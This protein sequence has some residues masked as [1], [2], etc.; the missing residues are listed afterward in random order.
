MCAA[1]IVPT[2]LNL[3]KR[4]DDFVAPVAIDLLCLLLDEAPMQTFSMNGALPLFVE[5]SGKRSNV[6]KQAG[7]KALAEF[8]KHDEQGLVKG[9]CVE[10]LAKQAH[11][12]Y[13]DL[14]D[15]AIMSL[16]KL[17]AQVPIIVRD[18]LAEAKTVET[19]VSRLRHKSRC[20]TAISA[21]VRLVAIDYVADAVIKSEAPLYIRKMLKHRWFDGN[22]GEDGVGA[23]QS[24]L[25]VDALR[26]RL[27]EVGI[28][29]SLLAMLQEGDSDIVYAGLQYLREVI[30]YDDGKH[31]ACVKEM[32]VP[33]LLNAL[34]YP[35][36]PLQRSAVTVLNVL[37]DQE[38][39]RPVILE[40]LLLM[41][42]SRKAGPLY[43]ATT[44]LRVLC[45][46]GARPQCPTVTDKVVEELRCEVLANSNF[47]S[48][49]H[50]YYNALDV[51]FDKKSPTF[52]EVY[53]SVG[54]LIT[55]AQEGITNNTNDSQW[56]ELAPYELEKGWNPVLKC[57]EAFGTL[58]HP[59]LSL[60]KSLRLHA[61]NRWK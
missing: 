15:G 33:A 18:V 46:S 27:L 37:F 32:I 23:L 11:N 42:K 12:C 49:S 44:A 57:A 28:V 34:G 5:M 29:D 60:F 4:C 30:R 13:P 58:L 52:R 8:A 21:L 45:F 56:L 17:N 3:A 22:D 43:G 54:L 48:L 55:S 53:Q 39:L 38:D 41:L 25:S 2:L 7:A 36:A 19:L 26:A 61:T 24:L 10:K 1:A 59:P 47:W 20:L 14:Q 50:D 35:R 9:G 40:K 16:V 51:Q 31:A 6:V